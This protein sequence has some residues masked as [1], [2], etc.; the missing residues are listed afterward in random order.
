[1]LLDLCACLFAGIFIHSL[2][3]VASGHCLPSR[4]IMPSLVSAQ[5]RART[6]IASTLSQDVGIAGEGEGE[7]SK[8]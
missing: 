8:E 3:L 1:M 2:A 7:R 5:T 6:F 4:L